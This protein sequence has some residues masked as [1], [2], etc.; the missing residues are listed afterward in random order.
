[1]AVAN[2]ILPCR[3]D[4]IGPFDTP[5][6]SPSQEV[7]GSDE[8]TQLILQFL[9]PLDLHK[10]AQVCR[11]WNRIAV[12]CMLDENKLWNPQRASHLRLTSSPQEKDTLSALLI[13]VNVKQL[14]Y[15]NFEWTRIISIKMLQRSFERM[16]RLVE[17]MSSLR[18][19]R[20]HWPSMLEEVGITDSSMASLCSSIEGFLNATI[21][22]GCSKLMLTGFNDIL[23]KRYQLKKSAGTVSSKSASTSSQ[24]ASILAKARTLLA[25]NSMKQTEGSLAIDVLS[26]EAN[27]CRPGNRFGSPP[28]W[29]SIAP[30]PQLSET[31]KLTQFE[32][33]TIN[34]FRPPFSQWTLALLKA[35]PITELCLHFTDLPD[36]TIEQ[37]LILDRIADAAP[38]I[39]SLYID[40]V[41]SGTMKDIMRWASRFQQVQIL[42]IQPACFPTPDDD[43]N[44][45]L[46]ELDFPNLT[47]LESPASFIPQFL[48]SDSAPADSLGRFKSL[49]SGLIAAT[50]RWTSSS[51]S[52]VASAVNAISL[53]KSA[54]HEALGS[55]AED[56]TVHIAFRFVHDFFKVT[57]ALNRPGAIPPDLLIKAGES[58]SDDAGPKFILEL[59][60]PGTREEIRQGIFDDKITVYLRLVPGIDAMVLTS[61]EAHLSLEMEEF[62]QEQMWKFQKICPNLKSTGMA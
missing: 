35:S 6:P 30:S 21:A 58:T 51:S 8:L 20:V 44:L 50:Y 53:V 59:V 17:R 26:D 47:R 12:Q 10:S 5:E 56:C 25:P 24:R 40:S 29:I 39:T 22:Q 32:T 4:C 18:I 3:P 34:L 9:N 41:R 14:G 43:K 13:S 2:P 49:S 36:D 19:V 31:S 61:N 55:L 46:H 7:W 27:Y 57:E 23:G 48:K 1:M 16:Q 62:D 33:N 52:E 45:D 28:P 11:N 38:D 37:N 42:G 15:V 60:L 54:V